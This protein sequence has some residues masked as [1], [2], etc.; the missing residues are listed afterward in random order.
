MKAWKQFGVVTLVFSVI[1]LIEMVQPS[2]A[3]NFIVESVFEMGLFA[4]LALSL[5]L[6]Y[7]FTGIANLGKAGFF[8]IGAYA[9]A[10]L[11]TSGLAPFVAFFL[12]VFVGGAAGILVSLSTLRLRDQ[13]Y[14][15]LFLLVFG[16]GFR[17][18]VRE[19]PFLGGENGIIQIPPLFSLSSASFQTIAIV[20]GVLVLGVLLVFFLLTRS[21][22]NSPFGRSVRA[23][24]EDDVAASSVGKKTFRLKWQILAISSAMCG[25]AGAIYA[26]YEG[27]ISPD[28]FM[29]TVTLTVWIMVIVGGPSSAKG[30]V[31][32]SVI[33]TAIDRGVLFTSNL[34]IIPGINPLN[35]E[36]I[37]QG[38]LIIAVLVFRPG[39]L[40]KEDRIT[41]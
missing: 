20:N 13:T 25:A 35:L 26:Q 34:S 16:E 37:I 15:A 38:V 23:V 2:G 28:A 32:G 39:G 12:S 29:T 1:F 19:I 10:V 11:T 5:N 41:S 17:V 9:Y 3:S 22:V 24:R 33:V 14:L 21:L 7:G 6:E 30:A 8:M 18:T 31:L 27:A 4:I 40:A 36:Y